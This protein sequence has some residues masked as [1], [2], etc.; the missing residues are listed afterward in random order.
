M[1]LFRSSRFEM[2]FKIC[3][4]KIFAVFSGK[5]LRLSLFLIKLQAWRSATLLKIGFKTDIYPVNTANFQGQFFY[6]APLV[7]AS[8]YCRLFICASGMHDVWNFNIDLKC[9]TVFLWSNALNFLHQYLTF[10]I[11][12]CGRSYRQLCLLRLD[13]MR[14]ITTK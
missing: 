8:I 3:V 10:L 6:V 5:H 9:C 11:P 12:G 4:L 2:F 13:W 1:S 14:Y 7:A